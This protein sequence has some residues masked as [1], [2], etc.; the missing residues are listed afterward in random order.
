MSSLDK[1]IKIVD[2]RGKV[3]AELTQIMKDITVE[4]FKK[5]LVKHSPFR[6]SYLIYKRR[7]FFLYSK[8]NVLSLVAVD[9]TMMSTS[10]KILFES[11]IFPY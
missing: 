1:T 4:E 8:A 7:K 11:Q 9:E 3:L 6:K 10:S 2:P 5:K